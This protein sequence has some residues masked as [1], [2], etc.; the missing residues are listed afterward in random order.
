MSWQV[1]AASPHC[2]PRRVC[3]YVGYSFE[4][5]PSSDDFVFQFPVS[6]LPNQTS[7]GATFNDLYSPRL[8]VL[9]SPTRQWFPGG[10]SVF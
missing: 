9:V 5:E 7:L 6:S 1:F 2:C 8:R 10:E 4:N 3:G